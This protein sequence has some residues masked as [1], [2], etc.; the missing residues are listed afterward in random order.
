MG[1]GKQL[2]VALLIA[3][4]A[5]GHTV[6]LAAAS[7]PPGKTAGSPAAAPKSFASPETAAQGLID[8]LKSGSRQAALDILGH[9]AGE[10]LSSG[11]RVADR[12]A[13]AHFI[14]EF[15][16]KHHLEKEGDAR[17]I[18]IVGDDD[19]PFPFPIVASKDGWRFDP[20]QGREEILNRRIG[21]NELSTIQTLLAIV[22]AQREY[23][24]ADRNGDGL[25]EYARKFIS[26]PGKKDG[27][28]WPTKPGE[29]ESPLGPLI[30]EATR[31]GYTKEAGTPTAYHGY[32]Y[33]MLT[34][35]GP[36]AAGGAYDYV[37][38]NDRMIGGFAI[39]AYPAK[40]GVS[41]IMSFLVNQQGVVFEKDLGPD[42][43]KAAGR[44]TSFNPDTS[45]RKD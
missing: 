41:G 16:T 26:S 45:W 9:S 19:Y 2:V 34:K 12:A 14:A 10:W 11:D 4:A 8:A 39:V 30:G 33:R 27:L 7:P 38:H 37:V 23:A 20:E 18:L 40:Y 35:Q 36:A 13:V 31:E 1:V 24:S 21:R 3:V 22:D 44:I 17:A 29:S 6:R 15:D 28:Y 32:Y 42:T 43:G 25:L 5:A